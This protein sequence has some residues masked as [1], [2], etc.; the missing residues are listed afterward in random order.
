M[1]VQET[2]AHNMRICRIRE[3]LSQEA[4]A[5]K[6]GL[7]RTYI[8]SIE[9][10]SCNVT[11]ETV[12]K[13]A[14]A[15]DISPVEL[16]KEPLLLN[17]DSNISQKLNLLNSQKLASHHYALCEWFD[18]EDPEFTPI[19]VYNEDLT[20]RILCTLIQEGYTENLAEA[21]K[22]VEE[23]IIKYLQSLK[24]STYPKGF[25]SENQKEETK[26]LF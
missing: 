12:Q 1:S 23:P 24:K 6:C 16:L 14:M 25:T 13:I 21:Y 9:Q 10:K 15:L 18:G 22:R 7:H 4:L 20:L 3:G 2:F 5:E 8:G 26:E 19:D 11:L 17:S